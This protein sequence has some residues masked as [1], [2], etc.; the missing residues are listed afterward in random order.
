MTEQVFNLEFGI[1]VMIFKEPHHFASGGLVIGKTVIQTS[2]QNRV[3]HLIYPSV[4]SRSEHRA[5]SARKGT[6]SDAESDT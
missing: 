2:Y 1:L 6:N 5:T 3:L 4:R